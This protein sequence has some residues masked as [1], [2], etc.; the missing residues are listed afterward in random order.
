MKSRTGALRIGT[1]GYQYDHW[2]GTFYPEGLPKRSWF[3]YYAGHFDTVEINNTFYRLPGP[4]VFEHWREQAPK[5]F[6]FA[7][8]Y[9]RYGSHLKRLKDPE[10]AVE[11]FLRSA[12]RLEETFGP[13][14]VQLPPR[15]QADPGRLEAFLQAAG[16]THRW[17]LEFRDASWLSESV[18]A[19]LDRFGAALCIHDHLA[20]HPRP[21]TAGFVYLRYHGTQAGGD[22][23]EGYLAREADWIQGRLAE[24]L[25]V[26]AYFNN[27]QHGHAL[28]NAATLKQ[29]LQSELSSDLKTHRGDRSSKE[30]IR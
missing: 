30:E 19:I 23:Q 13:I 24:G 11:R 17:T 2:K 21:V 5:G 7:V 25:D 6:C 9:S 16:A 8:K 15:W 4:E 26:Y 28:R 27:D 3:G 12:E 14:L 29:L 10:P 18:L 1:S 22:Y 20:E